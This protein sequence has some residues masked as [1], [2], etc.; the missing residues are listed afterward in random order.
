MLRPETRLRPGVVRSTSPTRSSATGRSIWS[1]SGLRVPCGGRLGATAA[2]AFPESAGVVLAVD[3]V[4][5]AR[6][7]MSDPVA[8][9]PSMD[10]RMDDIR[11][12]MD[13]VGSRARRDVR[14]LGGRHAQPAVRPRASRAAPVGR[15]LRLVGAASGGARLSVR[16]DCRGAGGH[17]SR[18][19]TG[20]G[21][22]AS[23][24][25]AGSPSESDDARHR[26]WWARYLR[27][28]ASPAMAQNVIRMNMRMDIRDVLPTI[29]QPA[30]IL[31][32]TGDTLDRCRP[33]ALPGRAPSRRRL[34]RTARH[35]PPAVARRRR[36]HRGRGRGVP[37]R[38]QEPTAAAD[39]HGR[40][41]AEP[42]RAR[43]GA[44][45]GARRDGDRDRR[46]PVLSKRTVESHLVSVYD[47]LGVAS[48]T[49]LIR[50]AGEFG[51]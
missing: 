40:R 30:L 15:P 23:G 22:R 7:G 11:A 29:T 34:C 17:R 18:A 31:H 27:M 21:R 42:A 43:G 50:R 8:G 20:P 36:R 13:A 5:Q 16:P 3:R 9:P 25:T 48:K 32:R 47:K 10:E 39:E 1:W 19:W 35:G 37:D 45:D 2:G 46:P 44:T 41:C 14:H 33:R 4:R 6:H 28:A 38:P 24:G 26:V 51:I 12:V 49:E